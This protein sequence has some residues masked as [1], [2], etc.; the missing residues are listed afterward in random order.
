[1]IFFEV[2][3]DFYYNIFC[4]EIAEIYILKKLDLSS[5]N[6]N[7]IQ[8]V[9]SLLTK[10][11][12]IYKIKK[13]SSIIHLGEYILE[14]MR[15]NKI[16]N[17]TY[18]KRI[19]FNIA[20]SCKKLNNSKEGLDYISKLKSEFELTE[21]ELSDVALVEGI[22]YRQIGDYKFAEKSFMKP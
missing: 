12:Y 4:Y 10:M 2:V 6:T 13:D 7:N 11:K 15:N 1:M 5:I 9:E 19:Y 20:L 22:L 16:D 14:Y 17:R 21:Y 18:R 3:I 8:Y